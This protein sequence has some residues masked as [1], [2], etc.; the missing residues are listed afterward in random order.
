MHYSPSLDG[1]ATI[2]SLVD[3]NAMFS[4][5][6]VYGADYAS[7]SEANAAAYHATRTFAPSSIP[8]QGKATQATRTTTA[9]SVSNP[10]PASFPASFSELPLDQI[11]GI[12]GS[13]LPS[14]VLNY[15]PAFYAG[16]PSSDHFS[17]ASSL[18]LNGSVPSPF[19]YPPY[20]YAAPSSSALRTCSLSYE[21]PALVNPGSIKGNRRS[22]STSASQPSRPPSVASTITDDAASTTSEPGLP[23]EKR[24]NHIQNEKR[25]RINMQEAFK[26]L[27]D[28]VPQMRDRKICRATLLAEAVSH[29]R[30]LKW[31]QHRA[32]DMRIEPQHGSN[33]AAN[34]DP[35]KAAQMHPHAHVH[36]HAPAPTPAAAPL[37]SS[38]L[39]TQHPQGSLPPALSTL[40]PSTTSTLNP[41]C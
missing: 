13:Q 31:Q 28:S 35:I 26:S 1:A 21:Q 17:S 32:F 29:I 38:S 5:P 34:N 4:L 19:R 8:N 33:A 12:Q 18:S 25:R 36:P 10:G 27:Q 6:S 41:L 15:H 37:P 16:F 30:W 11:D 9:Q 39:P 24:L 23:V 2:E 7:S 3:T 20:S 40:A 22:R 14:H